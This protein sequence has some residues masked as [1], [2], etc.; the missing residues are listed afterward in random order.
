MINYDKSK[1][2]ATNVANLFKWVGWVCREMQDGR[3]EIARQDI[4]TNEED[5]IKAEQECTELD[6]ANIIAEQTITDL[7][8]RVMMLEGE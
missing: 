7:D 8:I 3:V 2:L 4:R 1:T 6:L 5:L